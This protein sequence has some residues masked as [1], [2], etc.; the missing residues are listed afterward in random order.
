MLSA[1][2]FT[3]CQTALYRH[4]ISTCPCHSVDTAEQLSSIDC[5]GGEPIF[6]FGSH[7][8]ANRNR[9]NVASLADHINDGPMLFARF[10]TPL[11]RRIPAA[12]WG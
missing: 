12:N 1:D 7:P 9:S 10:F 3:M 6:Q 5:G 4:P 8:I 2:S 11:T